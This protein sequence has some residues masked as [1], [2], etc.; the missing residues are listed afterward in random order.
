MV[1]GPSRSEV[2][3]T[4]KGSDKTSLSSS[5]LLYSLP[6]SLG[7]TPMSTYVSQCPGAVMR[8]APQVFQQRSLVL[9]PPLVCLTHLNGPPGSLETRH[10]SFPIVGPFNA[11][12]LSETRGCLVDNIL[13]GL[14]SGTCLGCKQSIQKVK[15]SGIKG[16]H[17]RA[18]HKGFLSRRH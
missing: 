4:K 18:Q 11:N 7:T 2:L 1:R 9:Q 16:S 6:L 5:S 3:E 13:P 12:L 15:D 17:S 14:A 10:H 8:G